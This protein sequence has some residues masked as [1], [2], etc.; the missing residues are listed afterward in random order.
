MHAVKIENVD[1]VS[2]SRKC[3]FFRFFIRV[4]EN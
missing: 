2:F 4:Y 3:L 1:P